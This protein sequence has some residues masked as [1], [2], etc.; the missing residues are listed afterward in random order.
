MSKFMEL[1]KEVVAAGVDV[2]LCFDKVEGKMYADL[3]F[4]A[5][6]HGY[7]YEQEDGSLCVK[8]R[9]D[10]TAWVEDF[11]DLMSCF[12]QALH[13]REYG[14]TE[15]FGLCTKHGLLEK[16]VETTTTVSYR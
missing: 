4:Q 6:S 9:Y 13:G 16:V 12:T 3:D 14:N 7:L 2:T 8:M 15:W 10:R 11:H 5:K 1:V